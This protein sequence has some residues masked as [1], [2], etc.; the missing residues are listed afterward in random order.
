MRNFPTHICTPLPHTLAMLGNINAQILKITAT[1]LQLAVSFSTKT[2]IRLPTIILKY[3]QRKKNSTVTHSLI[4]KL[5]DLVRHNWTSTLSQNSVD[6][7][8]MYVLLSALPPHTKTADPKEQTRFNRTI[9]MVHSLVRLGDY[10][11]HFSPQST[12]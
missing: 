12:I 2:G 9:S 8:S 10:H 6:I 7:R 1:T 5:L 4:C 3:P 11:L